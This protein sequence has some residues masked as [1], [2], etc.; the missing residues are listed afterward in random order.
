MA[1]HWN[2]RLRILLFF[3]LLAALSIAGVFLGSWLGYRKLA[4]PASF[5]GFTI[6]ALVASFAILAACT[7]IWLLFD[8]HVAKPS[9]ELAAELRARAHSGLNAPMRTD[10]ARYLG[11]LGPAA[12]AITQEISASRDDMDACIASETAQIRSVNE[13]LERVLRDVPAGVIVCTAN[14]RVVLYNR[15][16]SQLLTSLGQL[17]L[18]RPLFELIAERPMRHALECLNQGDS[19]AIDLVCASIDGKRM[20]QGRIRLFDHAMPAK[21]LGGYVLTL[22]DITDGIS[23]ATTLD[24]LLRDTLEQVRRASANLLS[25]VDAQQC[26]SSDATRPALDQLVR[27]ECEQ[28]AAT[29]Q[30][31]GQ[32]YCTSATS[33]WPTLPV[34]AYDFTES[35]RTR[36]LV[37][38][39]SLESNPPSLS[40]TCD[41]FALVLVVEKLVTCLI[42]RREPSLKAQIVADDDGVIIDLIFAGPLP[43]I[44][45]LDLILAEPIES[46]YCDQTGHDV[47]LAHNAEIWPE[48]SQKGRTC[49]H[50]QLLC[51]VERAT[52]KEQ[53]PRPEFYD[54]ALLER[55]PAALADQR[56]LTDLTFVVFDSETTGLLP[57][58]GDEMVQLAACRVLNGRIL[59]GEVFDELINPGRPIPASS[60]KIHQIDDA[61]VQD[62]ATPA[63]TV[64]RFHHYALDSVLVAHNARFDMTFLKRR[65]RELGVTFD[66]PILDTVLLSAILYGR[67]ADHSL[68]ALAERLHVTFA[69]NE[70]HTAL[71][72][73]RAT[74]EVLVRLVPMLEA[75]NINTLGDLV[76]ATQKFENMLK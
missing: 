25:L 36:L 69:P 56:L 68:D 21:R 54:F 51:P 35:L 73:A 31:L 5:T 59:S 72:D 53:P 44:D 4:D 67:H 65:E 19:R 18:D 12:G 41:A 60:T 23:A 30:S 62:A 76:P 43:S 14:H 22:N 58:R 6:S 75:A 20:L 55:S 64:R 17:G 40:F 46:G 61:M 52:T 33:L 15:Q 45:R 39:L 29:I 9:I 71:G 13:R 34:S 26:V 74:A 66:Q 27:A 24:R 8:E 32:A 10:A 7:W 63:E 11:D 37:E 3:G 57:E 1:R 16:A 42:D 47:L 50:V 70:R 38:G 28:L 2:L 49:L 48:P